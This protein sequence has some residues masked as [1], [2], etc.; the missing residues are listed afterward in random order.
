MKDLLHY[1]SIGALLYCPANNDSIV[2]SLVNEKFGTKFSL[3]LCLEDTIGDSHV[4]EAED[5]LIH[6]LKEL[7]RESYSGSFF[8][9][10]I[11][12]RVRVPEQIPSLLHRLEEARTL[13]TGFILPKFNPATADSYIDEIVAA[14][15]LYNQT[16]YMM[17]ILESPLMVHLQH[18]ASILYSIKEKLDAVAS[19][20][21]NVRVGGNDL[22][23]TMG[24]RR[25]DTESIHDIRPIANILSDI[26]T[27]FSADY[28][29]S[30]AVWEYYNGDNWDTG[31]RQ[32]LMQDRLNGFIGKTVVHPNQI[33][34][35]NECY[36]VTET[37][38][39]DA[40]SILNWDTSSASLV[41][42]NDT[43]ERMNEYKTH[44]NWAKNILFLA[45]A[46]G[47]KE[48]A[49]ETRFANML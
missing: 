32:E 16:I 13:V 21:L 28:V 14:N 4:E 49:E 23:H 18:R 26:L 25:H 41:S 17:P 1:Y 27:V 48:K 46:Y 2:S 6:S 20:V 29:V 3:A 15:K 36:Q 24:L 9:P 11:F 34:L 35:V 22:C 47:V 19:Y 12:I 5:Q 7:F 30:G 37:D 38:Y 33:P 8:L 39:K 40:L 31:L 42:G 45:E 44:Y 43:S 10:K